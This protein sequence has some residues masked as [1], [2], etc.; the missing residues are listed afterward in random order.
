MDGELE[1]ALLA[2]AIAESQEQ[3]QESDSDFPEEMQ[4]KIKPIVMAIHTKKLDVIRRSIELVITH[5]HDHD[6]QT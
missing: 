5:D 2:I 6:I 3:D 1:D 4:I